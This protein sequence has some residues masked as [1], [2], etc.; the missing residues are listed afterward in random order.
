MFYPGAK[1]WISKYGD[2]LQKG[3]VRVPSTLSEQSDMDEL[4]HVQ[5]LETGIVFGHAVNFLFYKD[6]KANKWPEENRISV[7][8]LESLYVLFLIKHTGE[9]SYSEFIKSLVHFYER[10]NAKGIK[11]FFGFL[12]SKESDSEKIEKILSKRTE[13]KGSVFESSIF[14]SY[15]NNSF[16]YLDVILY[17]D[18]LDPH[19]SSKKSDYQVYAKQALDVLA[20][21][22]QADGDVN[23]L[24]QSIFDKFYTAATLSSKNSKIKERISEA[25]FDK[26][27]LEL[28]NNQLYR[29]F[30]LSIA[31]LI[32][33]ASQIE[34]DDDEKSFLYRLADK[35]DVQN[36][37]IE[38]LVAIIENFVQLNSSQIQEY[39]PKKTHQLFFDN[40]SE[41]WINLLGR[42][43]EKFVIELKQ[44]KELISLIK[45]SMV[46]ELS[47]DEK[48]KVK[49]Q[50]LELLKTMPSLA[51]FMLPGGALL[52]PLVIK[53]IPS[54]IPSSF[55]DNEV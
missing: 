24:E 54:L 34:I 44:N 18:F 32:I 55:K 6:T 10:H 45:K 5:F 46:Q 31:I 52:L 53:I 25:D 19:Y 37:E 14:I 33:Y 11:S 4:L 12:N 51:I 27:N 9:K 42:N 7:L 17:S 1:G 29:Y 15:L 35:L 39:K 41:K 13:K 40:L 28:N 22:A 36:N 47:G 3:E 49:T 2:M 30:L 8:L 21:A 20:H 48:E 26:L 50:F 16:I 38:E 23:L 43:K